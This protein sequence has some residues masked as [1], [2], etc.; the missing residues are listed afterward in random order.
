MKE[1]SGRVVDEYNF[2]LVNTTK[3]S[4]EDEQFIY[5]SQAQQ[6]FYSK[7]PIKIGWSVVCRWK[8]RDTYDIP[9]L[10]TDEVVASDDA[11]MPSENSGGTRVEFMDDVNDN[12]LWLRRELGTDVRENAT[13]SHKHARDTI[14]SSGGATRNRRIILLGTTEGKRSTKKN[15]IGTSAK[16]K[17]AGIDPTDPRA[18]NSVLDKVYKGHHGGYERGLGI[19]W[20]RRKHNV[21]ATSSRNENDHLSAQLEEALVVISQL[22]ESD[23][24]K[25]AHIIQMEKQMQVFTEFMKASNRN[26]TSSS[27]DFTDSEVGETQPMPPS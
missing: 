25:F 8:P 14:Y 11:V 18:L 19:G 17:M 22:K 13:K 7:D 5:P 23:Q 12:A 4:F 20:S 24:E 3:K 10:P 27:Q 15:F 16:H 21:G 6:V 9:T 2:T 1:G 26:M